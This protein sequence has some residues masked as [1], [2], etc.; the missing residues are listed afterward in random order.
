LRRARE[1]AVR[2]ALGAGRARV[3]RQLLTESALLAAI[4]AASGVVLAV[5]RISRA[6]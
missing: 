5:W 3:V 2:C 4:G 1:I 6:A